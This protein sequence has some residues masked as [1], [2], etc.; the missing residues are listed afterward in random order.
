MFCVVARKSEDFSR[1]GHRGQQSYIIRRY[2]LLCVAYK[3]ADLGNATV[4]PYEYF[5]DAVIF[6]AALLLGVGWDVDEAIVGE[7]SAGYAV[8]IHVCC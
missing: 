8:F 7:Y 2:E 5:P 1:P 3:V 4:A 6:C